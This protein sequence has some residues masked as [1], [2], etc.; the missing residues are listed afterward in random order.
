MLRTLFCYGLVT[1]LLLLV[2]GKSRGDDLFSQ[3]KSD[4]VLGNSSAVA[5]PGTKPEDLRG[6]K[7]LNQAQLMDAFR[8]A[9]MEPLADGERGASVKLQHS[10]WTCS[11]IAELSE[12]NE[13]IGLTLLLSLI[14]AKQLPA[15][16]RV[17]ALLSANRQRKS[18]FFA[19]NS[20]RKCLELVTQITNERVTPRNLREELRQLATIADSTASSW[21]VTTST[22]AAPKS[23]VAANTTPAAG[24]TTA[25]SASPAPTPAPTPVLTG[26]WSATRSATEAFALLLNTDGSFALAYVK[27]G[28]TVKSTGQF[29]FASNQLTLTGSDSSK[30][31]GSVSN[32]T[33]KGFDFTIQGSAASKLQFQ[34]AP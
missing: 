5:T 3:I 33:E 15:A 17:L 12:D 23:V 31:V 11:F 2:A 8:D 26:R 29:T 25:P 10:R 19:Y 22:T 7:L 14:D 20:T 30:F 13:Q 34:K 27:D 9:G 4:S 32:A 1:G 18:A 16:D 28:K 24:S 21:E 6:R